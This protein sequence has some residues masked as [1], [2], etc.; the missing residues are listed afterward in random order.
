MKQIINEIFNTLKENE[1]V[2]FY[3]SFA[4]YKGAGNDGDLDITDYLSLTED[5][6]DQ[7]HDGV[8]S[9]W[10]DH[11]NELFIQQLEE[12]QEEGMLI[13]SLENIINKLKQ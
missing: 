13:D 1:D 3:E 10:E 5:E 2:D 7:I 4:D 8:E 9:L 12:L 6:L 11:K